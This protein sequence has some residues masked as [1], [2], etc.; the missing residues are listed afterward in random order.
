MEG[1]LLLRPHPLSSRDEILSAVPEGWTLQ[2]IADLAWSRDVQS[3]VVLTINGDF[4]P[5]EHWHRV[6]P[7]ACAM[8]RGTLTLHGGGDSKGIIGM[9][10]SI[11]IAIFAPY[12]AGAVFGL[13]A[14]TVGYSLAVAGITIV[15][16]MAVNALFKP[17]AMDV[18]G[19][20]NSPR[21]SPTYSISGQSNSATPYGVIPRHFGQ[22]KMYPRLAATPYVESV[23]SK[24]FLY[25]LLD[26]GYGPLKVEFLQIGDTPL[27]AYKGVQY[28]I[29]PSFTAGTPLQF[30]TNDTTAENVAVDLLPS[31]QHIRT[32]AEQT[33]R[34]IVDLTFPRGLIR[35]NDEG[36]RKPETG[37]VK[38]ELR[39]AGGG[40]WVGFN[41]YSGSVSHQYATTNYTSKPVGNGNVFIKTE[42][43]LRTGR[44]PSYGLKTGREVLNRVSG[45][46]PPVG[47]ALRFPDG[48]RYIVTNVVGNAITITPPL[49]QNYNYGGGPNSRANIAWGPGETVA[50]NG[51][52]YTNAK[53]QE[54]FTVGVTINVPS[55]QYDVR[56]T[57]VHPVYP[58]EDNRFNDVSWTAL[59]SAAKRP[60]IAP[61]APH[62][63]MELKI[64]ASDQLSG[65]IQS[66]NAIVTAQ[67][68]MWNGSALV[69]TYENNPAWAFLDVLIGPANPRPIPLSRIDLAG[70]KKWADYCNAKVAS[71]VNEPEKRFTF[72][73]I[74][75]Y[76]TTVYQMLDGIASAGRAT[77]SWKDNKVGVI[78]DQE[79][80][81][82]VQM[83]TPRNSKNFQSSRNY[84][85]SP[86]ALRCKFIDPAIDYQEGT[87]V[88]YYD[89]Y[90]ANNATKFEDVQLF[91]VTR[92]S[93]AW[94]DGRYIIAQGVLRR[95]N[96]SIETDV[97]NLVCLRGDLVAVQ[98]DVLKVGG[99]SSRIIAIQDGVNIFQY[100]PLPTLPPNDYGLRIRTRGGAI[101]GPL[102]AI[103]VAPNQWKLAEPVE[104][105]NE[106]DLIVWG[107]LG[108]ETGE[109][110]VKNITP[111]PDLTATIDLV[112]IARGVYQAD[113]GTLPPYEPPTNGRPDG[114]NPLPLKNL[115]VTQV[116]KTIARRPAVDLFIEWDVPASGNYPKVSLFETTGETAFLSIGDVLN[117]SRFSLATDLDLLNSR[118]LDESVEF[119]AQ[120]VDAVGGRSPMVYAFETIK[121]P[122][123]VPDPVPFFSSNVQGEKTTL[124]WRDPVNQTYQGNAQIGFY[125]IRWS[126]DTSGAA[127]FDRA[128]RVSEVIA[129]GTYTSTVPTRNGVYFIKPITTSGVFSK[130]AAKTVTITEDLNRKDYFDHLRFNA[131]GWEGQF[132]NCELVSGNL[133]LL[134]DP[135]TGEYFGRGFWVRKAS[136]TFNQNLLCRVGSY[137]TVYG[138]RDAEVLGSNYFVPLANAV[139][140][141]N[142]GQDE[143][144]AK[145]WIAG[146]DRLSTTIS[147]WIPIADAVPLAGTSIDLSKDAWPI[148]SGELLVK[149]LYF[150]VELRSF[151]PGVTPSVEV[152]G[153]DI[154]FP[155]RFEGHSDISVPA[156][157]LTLTFDYPFVF[158]P[159]TSITLQ[160]AAPG[161]YVE[162]GA[163]DQYQMSVFVRNSAGAAKLGIVDIQLWG[164]GRLQSA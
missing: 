95:E 4:I 70:L 145:V 19:A 78:I 140:L 161:D 116:D 24:Q 130:T 64:E 61:K 83:F 45:T 29:I 54:P 52:L 156:S 126:P 97:E 53:T 129:W 132:I 75:D 91:G 59:R 137:L 30:Y 162:R 160:N 47:A 63:I 68:K 43:A 122:F 10:A 40:S 66:F 138:V 71:Q 101:L 44:E 120:A 7:K 123:W 67:V 18:G 50:A 119:A 26:F 72:D 62:T 41:Y 154:D 118:Y 69:N 158:P 106:E 11:A 9:I 37:Q 89:G 38:I 32:T 134:H 42:D 96:F 135:D 25:M 147:E 107:F 60:P 157:G 57:R 109:Y 88:V 81:T 55:G 105:I 146:S 163:V 21:S 143:Y 142:V 27:N 108:V 85:E 136:Y 33:V 46:I 121:N 15:G 49:T 102:P 113:Q 34:I 124:T 2:Q 159:N 23:A 58:P 141:A 28:R 92:S 87:R 65:V 3:C 86:H 133:R 76:A 112:E 35:F 127:T 6:R 153:V 110:L 5:R 151:T 103:P 84:L 20:S 73:H 39:P 48:D 125:D 51:I 93:Q 80:T 104:G 117:G 100:D 114:V 82:P 144:D 139:P 94:R 8:V 99:D 14:G 22:N 115:R 148:I 74:C 36:D 131:E 155:E 90:N 31:V 56:V 77:V 1:Q 17:P 150:I 149:Q 111:G 164:V 98:H 128:S 79:Q 12:M 152:A 16:N 13:Q